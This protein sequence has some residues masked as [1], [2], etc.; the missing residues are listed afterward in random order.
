MRFCYKYMSCIIS[1][2]YTKVSTNKFIHNIRILPMQLF[3]II[4][5]APKYY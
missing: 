1:D 3:V 5:H 2:K 4:N